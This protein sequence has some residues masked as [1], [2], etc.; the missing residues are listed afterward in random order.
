MQNGPCGGGDKADTRANRRA[1]EAGRALWG[2]GG[3][4]AADDGVKS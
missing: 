1:H 2:E 4:A 3:E